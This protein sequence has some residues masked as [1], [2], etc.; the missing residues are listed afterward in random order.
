MYEPLDYRSDTAT[1][2]TYMIDRFTITY[3]I[4]NMLGS[5]AA[6]EFERE[7]S[8]TATIRDPVVDLDESDIHPLLRRGRQSID[9]TSDIIQHDYALLVREYERKKKA[10]NPNFRLSSDRHENLSDQHLPVSIRG[11]VRGHSFIPDGDTSGNPKSDRQ[12]T[13]HCHGW[14][15]PRWIPKNKSTEL[16]LKLSGIMHVPTHAG[17]GVTDGRSHESPEEEGAIAEHGHIRVHP[18]I[19][20]NGSQ[21]SQDTCNA[22]TLIKRGDKVEE[23][24]TNDDLMFPLRRTTGGPSALVPMHMARSDIVPESVET[25]SEVAAVPAQTIPTVTI[26]SATPQNTVKRNVPTLS[27]NTDVAGCT[28]NNRLVPAEDVPCSTA[29][30]SNNLEALSHA[31]EVESLDLDMETGVGVL[32]YTE[33]CLPTVEAAAAALELTTKTNAGAQQAQYSPASGKTTIDRVPATVN[34]RNSVVDR[35]TFG[36]DHSSDLTATTSHQ[37]ISRRRSQSVPR[38]LRISRPVARLTS[39]HIAEPV[40]SVPRTTSQIPHHSPVPLAKR[41]MSSPAPSTT[42]SKPP[43]TTIASRAPGH[44]AQTLHL[45]CDAYTELVATHRAFIMGRRR[46]PAMSQNSQSGPERTDLTNEDVLRSIDGNE[47][48]H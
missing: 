25:L 18:D 12:D 4:K 23:T 35:V 16:E 2:K 15:P 32:N 41:V 33:S 9:D 36:A 6:D 7:V 17:A 39:I 14:R 11:E 1:V 42:S 5:H 3:R 44:Y 45:R 46:R 31:L 19:A 28:K 40:Q 27:P 47:G 43:N 26:L 37:A 30:R 20:T 10:L 29:D 22:D 24:I 13:D 21:K 34:G 8:D 48:I 38:Q